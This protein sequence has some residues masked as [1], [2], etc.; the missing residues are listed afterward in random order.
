MKRNYLRNISLDYCY[1]FLQYLDFSSAIWV[2]YLSWRGMTLLEIGLLEGIFHTTSMIFEIPSG[3]VADL[4]GRKRTVLAGRFCLFLS[5]IIMLCA[6]SFWGFALQFAVQALGYNLNSG[7]EEALVYDSLKAVGEE[8]RYLAVNSRINLLIELS[9]GL[10]RV[11]GGLLAEVSFYLCYGAA[12]VLSAVSAIPAALFAE[13]PME[14]T[15]RVSP[16]DHARTSWAI[17]KSSKSIRDNLI[18]YAIAFSFWATL[19][20]Y[21]QSYFSDFGLSRFSISLILLGVG[22]ASCVGALSCE[23][24]HRRL[25]DRLRVLA[26]VLVAAAMLCFGANCLPL[27]IGAILVGGWANALLPPLQSSSLNAL[28][29]S[30]QRA[31]IISVSSMLYSIAMVALFPLVGAIADAVGLTATFPALGTAMLLFL[32]VFQLYQKR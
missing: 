8:E 19:L 17:L 26:G 4:L 12:A 13:P 10:S 27:S 1:T 16:A 11:L 30:Q 9:S 25:G 31:T 22:L 7:A 29:P 32:L 18:Y 5:C 20:F 28:L 3:A 15:E 6:K 24:L 2:L 14:R 23:G 21:G